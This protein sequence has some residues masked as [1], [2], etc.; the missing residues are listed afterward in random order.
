MKN[1]LLIAFLTLTIISCSANEIATTQNLSSLSDL[2]LE[3]LT[4]KYFTND[5][6]ITTKSELLT[7]LKQLRVHLKNKGMETAE[8]IGRL[9]KNINPFT[10]GAA[11]DQT[12]KYLE[13]V[14][15]YKL[16]LNEIEAKIA[17]LEIQP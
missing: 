16:L 4:H 14:L 17:E 8:A 10:L 15:I 6:T 13:K 7:H 3:T 5:T 11:L 2:E 9:G 12:G 1:R